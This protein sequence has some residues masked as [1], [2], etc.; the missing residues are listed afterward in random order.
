LFLFSVVALSLEPIGEQ[1]VAW[2]PF[3]KL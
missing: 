3:M 2:P 1:K